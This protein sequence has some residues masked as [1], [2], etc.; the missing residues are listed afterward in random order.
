MGISNSLR[1]KLIAF[2]VSV[3]ST[4]A[5]GLK[6]NPKAIDSIRITYAYFD[7][8]AVCQSVAVYTYNSNAYVLQKGIDTT[9]VR[10]LPE[11]IEKDKIS[12]FINA[13]LCYAKEDI[14]DGIRITHDDYANYIK[15][16]D[17]S[18][19]YYLPFM[20]DVT[21]EQFKLNENAFISLSC[22]EIVNVLETPNN[23]FASYK[24][25][26]KIELIFG[27]GDIISLEPKWYFEGTTWTVIH[28][29]LEAYL[30]NKYVMAFLNGIHFD[31]YAHFGER[32]YLL[33]QIAYSLN[34]KCL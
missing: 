13:Y 23:L 24:P 29:E 26:L 33:F 1:Y 11:I 17:D 19:S 22:D 4:N 6:H 12:E 31:K 34:M 20:Q 27:N 32:F 7:G 3:I 16:L 28:N 14:C 25:L 18:V 21:K 10:N 8:Y 9:N 5:F 2:L 30:D 15:V